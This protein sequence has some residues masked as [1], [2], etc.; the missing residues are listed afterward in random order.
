MQNGTYSMCM[1]FRTKAFI[2]LLARVVI[3]LIPHA[4][5]QFYNYNLR[6]TES[7]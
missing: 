2:A 6:V 3:F 7:V 5:A 1:Y 4:L